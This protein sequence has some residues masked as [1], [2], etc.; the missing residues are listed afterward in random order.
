MPSKS[1]IKSKKGKAATPPRKPPRKV[2]IRAQSQAANL[3]PNLGVSDE[4]FLDN[5]VL[6]IKYQFHAILRF[7]IFTFD[8]I[9]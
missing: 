3:E 4:L 5:E 9:Y 2:A 7:A 6:H 1:K 8:N